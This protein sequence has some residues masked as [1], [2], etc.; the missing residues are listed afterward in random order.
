MKCPRR[1]S[2]PEDCSKH[3]AGD[4]EAPVAECVV[5]AWNG[6]RFCRWV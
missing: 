3:V 4:S 6:T 2:G 5:C 1:A